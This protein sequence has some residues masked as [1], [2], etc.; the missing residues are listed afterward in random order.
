MAGV[1]FSYL[2]ESFLLFFILSFRKTFGCFG[3]RSK[4][5]PN[6]LPNTSEA[7]VGLPLA[8]LISWIIVGMV[9][10]EVTESEHHTPWNHIESLYFSVVTLVSYQI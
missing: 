10:F 6:V 8:A 4:S 1:A 7:G 9:V 2:A 3:Y 5:D